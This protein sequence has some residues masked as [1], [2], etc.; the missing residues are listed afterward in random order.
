MGFSFVIFNFYI[1]DVACPFD[2]QTVKEENNKVKNCTDL[3]YEIFKIWKNE[4]TKV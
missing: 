2:P 3:K 4:V 1:V